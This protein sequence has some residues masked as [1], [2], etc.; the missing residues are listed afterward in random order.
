MGSFT[1]QTSMGR[2]AGISA[3]TS[4]QLSIQAG[5]RRR[6]NGTGKIESFESFAPAP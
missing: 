4:L 1:A 3:A 5:M 2:S 6:F